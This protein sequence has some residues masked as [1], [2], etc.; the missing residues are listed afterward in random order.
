M[1]TQPPQQRLCEY[2]RD[3]LPSDR[4]Y[5]YCSHC[6]IPH[7][8]TSFFD[9][10]GDFFKENVSFFKKLGGWAFFYFCGTFLSVPYL[11]YV[12]WPVK[13]PEHPVFFLPAFF[14][15]FALILVLKAP[16]HKRVPAV[17]S[18]YVACFLIFNFIG[19]FFTVEP[20][21]P[22]N[23]ILYLLVLAMLPPIVIGVILAVFF[24]F[25]QTKYNPENPQ[26]SSSVLPQKSSDDP[27]NIRK[28]FK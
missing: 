8:L 21:P 15:T 9:Q 23:V 1:A 25:V 24:S 17:F 2:C 13:P 7:I 19:A 20:I 5:P 3:P 28:H 14:A 27:L 4:P 18:A 10:L 11:V 16:P 22:P 6:T 26:S 12:S